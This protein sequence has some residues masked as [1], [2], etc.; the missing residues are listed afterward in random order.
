MVASTAFT[1]RLG[2]SVSTGIPWSICPGIGGQLAPE[3]GGLVHQNLQSVATMGADKNL[4]NAVIRI[5]V[6]VNDYEI[7]ED[8]LKALFKYSSLE[9]EKVS[10]FS[11]YVSS[12]DFESIREVLN[13]IGGEYAKVNTTKHAKLPINPVNSLITSVLVTRR[14]V[15]SI[16]PNKEKGIFRVIPF[17]G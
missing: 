17:Q 6:S 8:L 14:F 2:W 4:A 15:S 9:H 12:L 1:T 10:L 3:S 13:D 5:L 7:D 11:R 16:K